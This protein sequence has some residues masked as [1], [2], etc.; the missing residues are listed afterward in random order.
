MLLR[1]ESDSSP[2]G[3][4]TVGDELVQMVGTLCHDL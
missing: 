1:I 3:S 2:T 4:L